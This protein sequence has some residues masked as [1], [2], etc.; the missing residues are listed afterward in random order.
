MWAVYLRRASVCATFINFCRIDKIDCLSCSFTS[1]I[2]LTNTWFDYYCLDHDECKGNAHDCQQKCVNVPGGYY[3]DCLAGYRLS[4]EDVK[5]CEGKILPRANVIA[6]LIHNKSVLYNNR[7]RVIWPKIFRYHDVI[8][9]QV[10]ILVKLHCIATFW[11]SHVF[12]YFALWETFIIHCSAQLSDLFVLHYV[13]F[14]T[15]DQIHI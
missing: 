9:Y 4:K 13:L 14:L 10:I 7:I 1:W 15:L 3:C 5:S 2:S 11:N 6:I 8:R 12:S